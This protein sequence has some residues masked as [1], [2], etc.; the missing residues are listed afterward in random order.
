MTR[1]ARPPPTQLPR[2]GLGSAFQPLPAAGLPAYPP[3]VQ[4]VWYPML[5]GIPQCRLGVRTVHELA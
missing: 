4:P 3:P 1:I 5:P 2:D